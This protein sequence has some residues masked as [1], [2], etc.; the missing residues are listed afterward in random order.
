MY[1]NEGSHMKFSINTTLRDI[2]I[3]IV[4]LAVLSAVN[5]PLLG[6][7][8]FNLFGV[9]F[10]VRLIVTLALVVWLIALLPSP[11]R[12]IGCI[13]FVLWFFATFNFF[14]GWNWII[15][16]VLVLFLFLWILGLFGG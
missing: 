12:E 8:L 4:L 7:G 16:L 11:L 15:M 5:I 10:T 6:Y 14:G 13:F 1:Y 2:L 9:V 3:V